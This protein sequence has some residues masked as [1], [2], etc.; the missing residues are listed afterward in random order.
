MKK[1][2]KKKSKG[3]RVV[4]KRTKQKST[5]RKPSSKTGRPSKHK[6]EFNVAV[7]VM[8]EK[9]F[10]DTEIAKAFG[11]SKTTLNKWKKDYPEFLASIK[12]GK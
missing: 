3:E 10:I 5:T 12:G 1:S 8:A 7:R 4:S 6:P 11:I 9:G 2:H